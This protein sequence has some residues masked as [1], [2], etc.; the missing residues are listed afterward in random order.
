M[1]GGGL[2][3][4]RERSAAVRTQLLQSPPP[5][6]EIGEGNV[7]RRLKIESRGFSFNLTRCLRSSEISVGV[8]TAKLMVDSC[9]SDDVGERIGGVSSCIKDRRV[10]AMNFQNWRI[11]YRCSKSRHLRAE[12]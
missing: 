12:L 1:F 8:E 10:L 9:G 5:R 7:G 6:S 4:E 3:L 2:S 11:Q